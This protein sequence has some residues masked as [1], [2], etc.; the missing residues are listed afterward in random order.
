MLYLEYRRYDK[1]GK[2]V[3]S[4]MDFGR[5]VLYN[6]SI[7]SKKKDRMLKRLEKQYGRGSPGITFD[8]F[9]QFYHLLFG[10]SDL[11]RAMFFLNTKNSEGV[12][13]EE[14]SSIARWVL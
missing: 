11:E 13:R 9:C 7:P 2:D 3:I 5:H 10:G 8:N 1:E 6:T 4:E 12:D 14:F